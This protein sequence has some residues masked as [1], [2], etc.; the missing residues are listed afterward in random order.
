VA[1]LLGTSAEVEPVLG[2]MSP[3]QKLRPVG[4]LQARGHVE[5]EK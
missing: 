1:E 3:A 5:A 2:R 4:A